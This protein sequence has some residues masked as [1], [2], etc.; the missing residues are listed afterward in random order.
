MKLITVIRFYIYQDDSECQKEII[1]PH[2]ILWM[3]ELMEHQLNDKYL[4]CVTSTTLLK[5]VSKHPI[6]FEHQEVAIIKKFNRALHN[7]D[8]FDT[9]DIND[10][11]DFDSS[12]KSQNV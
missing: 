12:Q 10:D 4:C 6:R 1:N 9:P 5:I 7:I 2:T 8:V 3:L 11:S